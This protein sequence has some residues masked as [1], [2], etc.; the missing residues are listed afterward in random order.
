MPENIANQSN[1]KELSSQYVRHVLL[2]GRNSQQPIAKALGD[3][4]TSKV[5]FPLDEDAAFEISLS[6]LG[7]SLALLK[8]HSKVMTAERGAQI[9][10]YCKQSIENDFRLSPDFVME[11]IRAI[12]EY[13]SAVNNAMTSGKNPFG[14]I[15]GMMLVKC[16]KSEAMQLCLPGTG[17][18]NPIIH[19]VI[20]DLMA[21]AITE[22]ATFWKDR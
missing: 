5:S 14:D 1:D 4:A 18:L 7:A 11:T 13:Q 8:G 22:T 10:K 19:Q 20:G 17:N 21:L 2:A 9:E 6:I 16:L 12:D 3:L 15:S